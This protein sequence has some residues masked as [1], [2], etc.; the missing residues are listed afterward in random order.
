MSSWHENI[1]ERFHLSSQE[2]IPIYVALFFLCCGLLIVCLLFLSR[3]VKSYLLNHQLNL[4][5]SFQK[6]LNT[7]IINETFSQKGTPISAFEYRM[8]ELRLIRGNSDFA[9]QVLIDQILELKK[10]LSGSSAKALVATYYELELFNLSIQKLQSRQW[11]KKALGIRELAEMHHQKSIS[12]ITEFLHVR[13]QTLRE[14]SFMAL[15]RLNESDPLFFLDHYRRDLTPWLRLNIYHY[16]QKLQPRQIPLFSQW[17]KHPN[18]SVSLFAISMARQFRQTASIPA[19]VEMIDSPID[20]VVRSTVDTLGELEAYEYSEQV[21][22]LANVTWEDE[23]LATRVV[24]CLGK[25]GDHE[26]DVAVV[27]KFL[28]HPAYDVRFESVS[29]LKKLGEPGDHFLNT[30]RKNHPW[31]IDGMLRHISEPLLT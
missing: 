28:M 17:F 13:N 4:K 9:G 23:K 20:I 14:E 21:S 27:G 22:R 1:Q 5:S 11:K 15:V 6:I 12:V 10:N 29:A 30:F 18:V 8:A 24:R 3:I 31:S 7:I 2:L 16:L 25:I 19:L 26:R